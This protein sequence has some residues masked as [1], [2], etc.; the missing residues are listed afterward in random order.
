[1]KKLRGSAFSRRVQTCSF[2]LALHRTSGQ[3]VDR[4]A[5]V[6]NFPSP[7]DFE[8]PASSR[9]HGPNILGEGPG[10]VADGSRALYES[11]RSNK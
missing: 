11:S 9:P 7:D 8:A 10:S 6:S 1:M 4:C 2:G 3:S 5:G